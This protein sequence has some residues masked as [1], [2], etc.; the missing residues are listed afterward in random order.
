MKCSLL[1][2]MLLGQQK[3]YLFELLLTCWRVYIPPHFV[4]L[5]Y[6][7]FDLRPCVQNVSFL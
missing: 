4:F 2:H 1:Q 3:G 7:Q 6:D 5:T